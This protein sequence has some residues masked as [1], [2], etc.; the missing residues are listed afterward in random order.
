MTKLCL[1]FLTCRDENE[2]VNHETETHYLIYDDILWLP[3]D[4][5]LVWIAQEIKVHA[6]VK[7]K[8]GQVRQRTQSNSVDTEDVWDSLFKY[9]LK[10]VWLSF[11]LKD[12]IPQMDQK[13]VGQNIVNE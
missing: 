13:D 12:N 6:S 1:T 3:V 9:A 11:T 8:E 7:K 2:T 5:N 10:Y 4:C